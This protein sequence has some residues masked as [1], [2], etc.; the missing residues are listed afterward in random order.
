META[1]TSRPPIDPGKEPKRRYWALVLPLVALLV[2]ALA[3]LFQ[4]DPSQHKFYPRCMLYVTTGLQC[5]GCG[6]LRAA[7]ALL[8]GQVDLAFR[9]NPL[10]LVFGP[11]LLY[12]AIRET[13]WHLFKREFPPLFRRP[14]VLWTFLAVVLLFTVLR[15]LPF[16]PLAWLKA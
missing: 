6:G 7:H 14:A 11:I 10:L 5:P 4:F 13:A 3:V 9:L 1:Q 8:H 12:M 15:N 16:G 2:G